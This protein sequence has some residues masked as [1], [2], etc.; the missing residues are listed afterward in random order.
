M[1]SIVL[2]NEEMTMMYHRSGRLLDVKRMDG[3]EALYLYL[4]ISGHQSK[5]VITVSFSRYPVV[6]RDLPPVRQV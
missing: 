3:A 6:C 4:K 1:Y 5:R 2:M